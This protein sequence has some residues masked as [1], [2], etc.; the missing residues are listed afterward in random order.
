MPSDKQAY[1]PCSPMALAKEWICISWDLSSL[2]PWNEFYTSLIPDL[3]FTPWP[4]MQVGL[5][6]AW[7]D[8]NDCPGIQMPLSPQWRSQTEA[9][10]HSEERCM[11]LFLLHSILKHTSSHKH[12]HTNPRTPLAAS[13]LH[14]WDV[15]VKCWANPHK[16]KCTMKL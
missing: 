11:S 1:G 15:S 8:R 14:S 5:P 9:G 2:L 3:L 13:T 16:N 10:S 12:T 7:L 6:D 4:N